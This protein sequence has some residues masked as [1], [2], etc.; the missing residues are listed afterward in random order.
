[1]ITSS[2]WVQN[3]ILGDS[4]SP[5]I[6][7]DSYPVI[8]TRISNPI[9]LSDVIDK[10]RIIGRAYCSWKGITPQN[11]SIDLYARLDNTD[12][13]P[14]E[15]GAK[16]SFIDQ[17]TQGNRSLIIKQVLRM[18]STDYLLTGETPELEKIVIMFLRPGVDWDNPE[19]IQ[20]TWKEE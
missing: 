19:I 3:G 4:N 7:W 9:L 20:L 10:I 5:N 8:G 14:I 16:L 18:N 1:V 12:W 15:N 2:Q 11:T 17:H 13:V 6:S